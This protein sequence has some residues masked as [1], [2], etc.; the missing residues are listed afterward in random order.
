MSEEVQIIQIQCPDCKTKFN[1]N[2]LA[3]KSVD[4]PKF[5]CSKCDHIFE[6]QNIS[7]EAEDDLEEAPSGFGGGFGRGFGNQKKKEEEQLKE[8][9]EK[10]NSDLKDDNDEE[11]LSSFPDATTEQEV[12]V[13]DKKH[14]EQIDNNDLEQD[15]QH[16]QSEQLELDDYYKKRAEEMERKREAQESD[17]KHALA[18]EVSFLSSLKFIAPLAILLIALYGFSFYLTSN[19]QI[20]KSKMSKLIGKT[21]S[22][23]PGKLIISDVKATSIV[24]DSGETTFIVQGNVINGTDANFSEVL[25][26]AVAFDQNGRKLKSQKAYLN[27]SLGKT[28]ITALNPRMIKTL[29]KRKPIKRVELK[30]GEK[31][32]FVIALLDDQFDSDIIKRAKHY[33]TRIY[34]VI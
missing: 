21:Q 9:F 18:K 11:F 3:L 25:L 23:A 32:K 12:E 29:Q 14:E 33:V 28:R 22:I 19:A 4:K 2:A 8:P 5:H 31:A 16:Y 20:A 7:K 13:K 17:L 6:I 26:E 15:M 24:L 1:L 30:P 27:S 10:D 34:S